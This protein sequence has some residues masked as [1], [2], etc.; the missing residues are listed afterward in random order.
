MEKNNAKV[1]D[2]KTQRKQIKNLCAACV[3]IVLNGS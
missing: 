2:A 3:K 1:R